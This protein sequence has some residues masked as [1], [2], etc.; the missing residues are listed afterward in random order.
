MSSHTILLFVKIS[1]V[2]VIVITFRD[3]SIYST[4]IM[5]EVCH[6]VWVYIDKGDVVLDPGGK[7]GRLLKINNVPWLVWLSGLQS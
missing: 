7:A 5:G 4:S 2:I 3:I 1:L 6:L